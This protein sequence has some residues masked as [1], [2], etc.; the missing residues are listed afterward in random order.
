MYQQGCSRSR[1]KCGINKY[2]DAG[3]G[4]YMKRL[5]RAKVLTKQFSLQKLNDQKKVGVTTSVTRNFRYY[6]W[7]LHG[8]NKQVP[9]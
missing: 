6:T 9:K 1:Y 8:R 2:K 5:V 7:F 4:R 3:V